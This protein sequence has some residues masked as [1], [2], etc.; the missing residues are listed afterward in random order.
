MVNDTTQILLIVVI[1]ILTLLLSAIGVQ[2]FL[3]L[4]EVRNILKK[5]GGMLDDAKRITH[6]VAE[7]VEEASSFMLGLKNGFGLVKKIKKIFADE[8]EE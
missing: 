1:S 8:E 2:M 7:P 6:A 4:T 3:I 5:T